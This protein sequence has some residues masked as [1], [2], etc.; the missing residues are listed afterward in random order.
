VSIQ[1]ASSSFETYIGLLST[2]HTS[3]ASCLYDLDKF[4]TFLATSWVLFLVI[5]NLDNSSQVLILTLIFA[6]TLRCFT[7]YW[8]QCSTWWRRVLS[9]LLRKA[10]W[11]E[12]LPN[13]RDSCSWSAPCAGRGLCLVYLQ[14]AGLF[15][16]FGLRPPTRP[17]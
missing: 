1:D 15:L 16:D 12:I 3:L 14:C 8:P 5:S 6:T 7:S 2:R 13:V 17:F 11:R 9:R 10:L 4:E